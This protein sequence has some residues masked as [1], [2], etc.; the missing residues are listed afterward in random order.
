MDFRK[1]RQ[2]FKRPSDR[3]SSDD[4]EEQI[5]VKAKPIAK[6][7]AQKL[8][9]DHQARSFVVASAA[10]AAEF[11]SNNQVIDI[12]GRGKCLIRDGS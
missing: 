4:E 2:L 8:G 7:Y 6:K 12:Q 1:R 11:Y 3:N 9:P 5:A 10:S